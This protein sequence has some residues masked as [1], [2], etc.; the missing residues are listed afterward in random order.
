MIKEL[1]F[2]LATVFENHILEPIARQTG[3]NN[4]EEKNTIDYWVMWATENNVFVKFDLLQGNTHQTYFIKANTND[5]DENTKRF[6]IPLAMCKQEFITNIMK[7][8]GFNDDR[9]GSDLLIKYLIECQMQ[10]KD[11]D[12]GRI[13]IDIPLWNRET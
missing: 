5:E 6:T 12:H 1:K 7:L 9:Y 13:I 10:N 2:D 4:D 3:W 8:C 11:I